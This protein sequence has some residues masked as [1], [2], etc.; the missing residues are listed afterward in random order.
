MEMDDSNI[1]REG[2]EES[3]ILCHK[4]PLLH[5]KWNSIIW[6]QILLSLNMYI[7][8]SRATARNVEKKYNMLIE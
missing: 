1:I 2:G 7:A 3:G 4:I 6:K 5:V 8:N